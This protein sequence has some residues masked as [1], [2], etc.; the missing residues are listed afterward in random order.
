MDERR[1]DVQTLPGLG[2]PRG[3]RTVIV[4]GGG[5]GGHVFPGL[6]VAG[7]LAHRG[8]RVSWIGRPRGLE[9]ELVV[10]HGLEYDAVRAR[11]LVGRGALGRV[12]ALATLAP[13]S[14]HA[15]ALLRRRRALAVLGTGGYVCAPAVLGAALTGTPAVLLEPNARAGTA[16]RWLSARV[17]A[18][19]V[20]H[21][22][23]ADDLACPIRHTGVPVREEFF[24]VPEP[25]PSTPLRLLVLGGSQGA[26]DLN[27]A[28]PAA[29]AELG[30]RGR[31]LAIVHQAGHDHVETTRAA[32][33]AAAA[34]VGVEVRVCAF[35]DDVA[36]A[37]AETDLVVSRAGAITLAEICA[38]GRASLLVP[39]SL[40]G[41][42]Q[43]DNAAELEAAGAAR[44]ATAAVDELVAR[45][46]ELAAR[47]D[48]LVE[49]A[50]RARSLAHPRA[51]EEI[52]DLVLEAA[53]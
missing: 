44:V 47:P 13:A 33:A 17:R 35:L 50:R 23:A 39:L 12:L 28:L 16:N 26:L 21:A 30:R 24:S 53:A 42:H 20:A 32:W 36:G 45:L 6:A 4:A 3:P 10:S 25:R 27:R 14:V 38:A 43:A 37:M 34:P 18:A 11:P 9:R 15:A 19:A 51:A 41:G 31:P 52:A 22:S 5:S 8:C 2:G 7:V 48:R 29:C 46:E 49:M 1:G 40:A